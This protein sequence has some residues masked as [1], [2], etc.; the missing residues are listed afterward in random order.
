MKQRMLLATLGAGALGLAG[1]AHTVPVEGAATPSASVSASDGGRWSTSIQS[2]TQNRG[3]VG[4]ST[5]D[6][7]YGSAQWTAGSGPRISN[8][9]LVFT[10]AGTERDLTWAILSGSCGTA[11]LPLI[12]GSSF[13]ELNVG[14]GGRAQVNA[15]LPLDLPTSGTYHLDI[16]RN[17]QSGPESLVGCGNLKYSSR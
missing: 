7:S 6:K 5:R 3:D 13:P 11:P 15:V 1:C 16:Y 17:R 14:G 2:V 10:Y 12:P 8:V 9:N 4:Q